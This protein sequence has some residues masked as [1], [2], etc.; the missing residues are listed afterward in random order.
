MDD[1]G[2]SMAPTTMNS[3]SWILSTS[4]K[5]SRSR[6]LVPAS[7]FSSISI[8]IKIFDPHNQ[9][10]P[11]IALASKIQTLLTADKTLL[12]IPKSNGPQEHTY[13]ANSPAFSKSR[14]STFIAPKPWNSPF[15]HTSVRISD[16]KHSRLTLTLYSNVQHAAISSAIFC[17]LL[18]FSG[19]WRCLIGLGEWCGCIVAYKG[20]RLRH[21]ELR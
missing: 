6:L 12:D 17:R 2:G 4:R 18:P 14:P 13:P 9:Q 3:T 1:Y 11:P 20:L 8:S 7:N 15:H 16:S 19:N 10:P 21:G 5:T